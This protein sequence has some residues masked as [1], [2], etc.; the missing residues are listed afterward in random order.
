MSAEPRLTQG[1]VLL[2]AAL[3][4]GA[5]TE[6]ISL[7]SNTTVH[8][9]AITPRTL[10][11]PREFPK[12]ETQLDWLTRAKAIR[13]QVL[14]SCGLWPIPNR[15]PIKS[16]VF[17]KIERDG[18]SVEKVWLETLP[19]LF[20]GGNLYRPLGRGTGTFPA[21]LCPHGHWEQ[22]RLVDS[23]DASMPGLCINFARQGMIAF[24]YDMVGFNDTQFAGAPTN[25]PFYEIHRWFG[26]NDTDQLWNISLMG[27]QAWN[28]VRA[29]DFLE[30]L[31]DVDRG[32]LGCTGASGGGTQTFI[33]GAIDTRLTAVAP[34]VMVSH[35]M[36][37]GCSCENAPGLRIEY[38]NMEI[39]AAAAPR[40]QLLV[41]A[42]GD[43]TKTTLTIEGPAIA[44]IY[45]LDGVPAAFKAVCLNYGH[46]YN[47]ASRKEVYEWFGRWLLKQPNPASL[48]E[49]S[50]KKEQDAD[51]RVFDG[52]ERPGEVTTPEKVRDLLKHIHHYQWGTLVPVDKVGLGIFKGTV[53]TAWVHT[54][55]TPLHASREEGGCKAEVN[56]SELATNATNFSV[57]LTIKHPGDSSAVKASYVAP[58]SILT[59]RAPELL[60][61]ACA[62]DS[63][64]VCRAP[65]PL[66][67]GLLGKGKAVLEIKGYSM[68]TP[69]DVFTNFYT[70][71]NLS[72]LQ[73][74]V[75]DL[76]VCCGASG[77]VDPRKRIPFKVT[78]VGMGAAGIWALQAAPGADAVVAD[79]NALAASE[80]QELLSPDLFCP[81]LRNMGT[82]EGAPMLAAPHPL[83]LYNTGGKFPTS[84]IQR[85]YLAAGA[86]DKLRTEDRNLKAEELA[87]LIVH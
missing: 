45:E 60:V 25:R 20:V 79:C 61:L 13:E 33:L 81:G 71:Y 28:S 30:T 9:P 41:A 16:R 54:L 17:G 21:V 73:S 55:H 74:R 58:L 62:D 83:F 23:E 48:K 32:S 11:T 52:A 22:G 63:E 38:S 12:V 67:D 51:L 4:I 82:F 37:G 72:K 36:Q 27:L 7:S 43:W 76:L 40:P 49:T 85:A 24:S 53:M 84:S 77:S 69:A 29:V 50:F 65:S 78:L 19:G 14:V 3:S 44:H 6:P 2:L 68:G 39:A 56:A 10:D 87:D 86:E 46:N 15:T 75:R 35:S 80:D 42:T 18:Y 5:G 1:C 31:P 8:T 64:G 66:V 47:K 34:V 59:N 57:V 70:T 26:T